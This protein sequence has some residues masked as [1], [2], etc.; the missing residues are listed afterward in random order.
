[1]HPR[2]DI[3][4]VAGSRLFAGIER[5]DVAEGL[6]RVGLNRALDV[7][8]RAAHDVLDGRHRGVVVGAR[9]KPDG[10]LAGVYVNDLIAGNGASDGSAD[11][12]DPWNRLQLATKLRCRG[13]H[14]R[15]R[16]A[17]RTLKADQHVPVLER[18]DHRRVEQRQRP[19]AC[20]HQHATNDERGA[21]RTDQPRKGAVVARAEAPQDRGL[22]AARGSPGEQQ[23]AQRRCY[24]QRDD[25]RRQHRE[26]VGERQRLEEGARSPAHHDHR[27]DGEQRDERGVRDGA[28]HLGVGRHHD[29]RGRAV[30]AFFL[31]VLA[32]A[33]EDVVGADD[34]VVY[35]DR[36]RYREPGEQDRVEG[37]P[38]EVGHDRRRNQGERDRDQADQHGAPLE[39]EGGEGEGQE[40]AGDDEREREVADRLL[41]VGGRPEDPRVDLHAGEAGPQIL[42]RVLDPGGNLGGVGAGELLH[43]EQQAAAVAVDDSVPDQRLV[44]VNHV[45]HVVEAHL[46]V[47]AIDRH[48]AEALRRREILE[49]VAD[50]EPLVGRLDE[51]ARAGR[52]SLEEGQRRHQLRVTRRVYD[53]AQLDILVLELLGIDL[54]LKLAV[55]AAP[56]GHVRH[57][58]NAQQGRLDGPAGKYRRLDRR[59]LLRVE[60]DHHH[61][62]RR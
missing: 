26:H 50:L 39:E 33:P 13:A 53:L 35:D 6:I 43:D 48:L 19:Q 38:E 31:A 55:A 10:E 62:A 60:P 52:G 30:V 51:P 58:R 57:A 16:G 27:H 34:G 17:G 5:P 36:Y 37:L 22:A 11:V 29:V 56:D 49:G 2:K 46:A 24:R 3:E 54:H 45:R 42:E 21:R 41:D 23:Q 44:T 14:L 9:G 25:H 18:R 4:T 28:A 20:H 15:L 61:L 40:D 12:L 47:R 59:Q 8:L 32:Q 1:M 7:L